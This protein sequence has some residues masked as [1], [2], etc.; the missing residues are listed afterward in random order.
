MKI[1]VEKFAREIQRILDEDGL[2]MYELASATG[3]SRE[4][5]HSIINGKR[6]TAQRGTMRKIAE[7]TGRN[8]V[9]NGD[10][11]TFI[12]QERKIDD[13]LGK[14]ER[15]LLALYRELG[16]EDQDDVLNFV[17]TL[18]KMLERKKMREGTGKED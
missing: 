12:K 2:S 8:F 5:L 1:N 16:S 11:V 18:C 6:T 15:R 14:D 7:A 3:I 4:T 13:D 17:E 10:K 9:I